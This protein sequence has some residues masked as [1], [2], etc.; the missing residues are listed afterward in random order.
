MQDRRTQWTDEQ[1]AIIEKN[2]LAAV[3]ESAKGEEA[4]PKLKT[5]PS[6]VTLTLYDGTTRL[7]PDPS[8]EISFLPSNSSGFRASLVSRETSVPLMYRSSQSP[9]L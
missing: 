1:M 9:W 4:S 2:L 6:R 5:T 7:I 3:R 8:R